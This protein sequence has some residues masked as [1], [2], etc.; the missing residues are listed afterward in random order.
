MISPRIESILAGLGIPPHLIAARSLCECAEAVELELAE[1]GDDGR[2][3]RL[4]PAAAAA[5]RAMKAAALEDGVVLGIV[6]AFRSVERQ[7]EIV[8]R[9]LADGQSIDAVLCVSAPPGFS[10]HHSGHAVDIGAP[11]CAALE[12][13]FEQTAAYA[14]L[15]AR[16]GEFGF[17][18]SYPRGNR[19]GYQYEPWHWCYHPA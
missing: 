15:T 17:R 4:T 13:E 16:A 5:W 1:T 11:D 2:E 9:K 6:S 18:L 3:H 7:A 19:C 14:W 10:E 8:R 12:V